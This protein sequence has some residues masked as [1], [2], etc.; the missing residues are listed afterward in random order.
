[1]SKKMPISQIPIFHRFARA[2]LPLKVFSRALKRAQDE[3][4]HFIR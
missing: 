3:V 4:S 1:M 2:S